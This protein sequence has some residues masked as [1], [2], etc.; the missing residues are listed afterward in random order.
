M[1]SMA[2]LYS[3]HIDSM[4]F[5]GQYIALLAE[6]R[7]DLSPFDFAKPFQIGRKQI[8]LELAFFLNIWISPSIASHKEW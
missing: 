2:T 4:L 8:F 6:E 1:F 5:Q 3:L 7:V